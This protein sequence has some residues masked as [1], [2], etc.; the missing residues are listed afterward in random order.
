[1]TED[2]TNNQE[3]DQAPN[4]RNNEGVHIPELIALLHSR[5][6]EAELV[7]EHLRV[8]SKLLVA[9]FHCLVEE[10]LTRNEALTF[11]CQRGLL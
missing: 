7:I 10:G 8:D 5:Q 1:M 6:L 11:I 4:P 9:K 3:D 2:N